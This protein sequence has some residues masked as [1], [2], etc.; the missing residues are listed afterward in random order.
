MP[1]ELVPVAAAMSDSVAGRLSGWWKLGVPSA[2]TEVSKEAS[3]TAWY[4]RVRLVGSATTRGNE[5]LVDRLD[6]DHQVPVV[7]R[8]P[9]LCQ[10]SD[11]TPQRPPGD[12]EVFFETPAGCGQ[13][14]TTIGQR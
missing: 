9:R 10:C 7:C 6:V 3:S 8:Q 1:R 13:D 4:W 5:P 11:P 2:A 12:P 14:D